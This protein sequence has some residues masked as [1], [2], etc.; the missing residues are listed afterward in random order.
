[1]RTTAIFWFLQYLALLFPTIVLAQSP[2]DNWFFGTNAWI[3]FP[4]GGGAPIAKS[5]GLLS[6]NEGSSSISDSSGNLLFYTDGVTVWNKNHQ[7]MSNGTGLN[8]NSSST[9]SALIVPCS[10]DKYLIFTTD[11]AEKDN[12][13]GLRYSLVDMT[14]N[15][16]N[17]DVVG[18]KNVLLVAPASEKIA[19]VRDSAGT[20]FWVVGHGVGN[21]RFLSYHIG[22]DCHPGTPVI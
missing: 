2:Q 19:A 22:E 6:T 7:V 1:M 13:L 12:K 18:S 11:A 16:G 10:C 3:S 21:N 8:G 4:Q 9:H 14:K 5:G 17:G 20:G 15:N